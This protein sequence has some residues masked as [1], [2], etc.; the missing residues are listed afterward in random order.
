MKVKNNFDHFYKPMTDE[1]LKEDRK[2]FNRG[3]KSFIN[4]IWKHMKINK[5]WAIGLLVTAILSAFFAAFNPLLMQQLQ[6]SVEFEKTKKV[7]D[8]F[9]GFNWKIIL[10]IWIIILVITAI[11]TYIANL[12][13]NELGKKIEISLRNELTKKLIT[14][15]IE[16]YSNKKTGEILTKVVSDTQIIGMQASVIPNIIFTA[17]FT[18]IFTLITLFIT[19]SLYIGL[20]FIAL[21]LMF[22]ILFG[23]A[24]LPMRKLVF[25][26]RKI[27]TDINGDVTDRINTIKLIKANGTEEYEKKRFVDIH[28]IYYKK[29]K[30]ISYFQSVMISILFFAINTVQILMTIIALWLYKNDIDT[31]KAVLGP[32]LI[33]AGMLIGPVMQLLRA[34]VGMVQA[35]TSAQRIDEITATKQFI[36]NYALDKKGIRIHKIEGN[37]VFK[38][39]TFAYSDKPDNIIL[40]NF[41]L[42]LEQGKSYAFVGQTGVGKSTISKLLLRFY[43]PSSGEVLINNNINL[44]DVFLP[45]YLNHIGYVEQDPSVLLGTVLDNLRYVKP[46]ATDEEIILACKKAEL[47]DLVM[48]WPDQYNTILGERGF[49]LS[50]GQKQRLVIARMFLKDPQILILDEATSALDN[51][52]EKEIQY[53]LEELMKNRTSIT[54]AHRLSTIRNVDQIIVLAPKKG[55]IQTG[56]FKELVKKPGEFKDLYEAG[57]SKYDV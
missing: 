38:N 21:F 44:K 54:I 23:L 11:L 36:N 32:M 31:L 39:V 10:S 34:V 55:I 15:D 37:I 46:S 16:Y 47:H 25:N 14:T 51:V 12:F 40:P 30:Q 13:G 26:L 56:T 43:D 48:T 42:V 24:F 18:M 28:E 29:Y 8:N 27:I 7:F 35:S 22:G 9:W 5:K 1:E 45:S 4:V 41:N 52:V 17:F 50:G 53:K 49:I 57:F 33:C 20:F 19:T 2:S 3:R 6:F